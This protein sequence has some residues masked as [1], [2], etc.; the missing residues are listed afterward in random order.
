MSSDEF[1]QQ[2][3]GQYPRKKAAEGVVDLIVREASV[4]EE[5]ARQLIERYGDEDPDKLVN[6]ALHLIEDSEPKPGSEAGKV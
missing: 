5:Q 2:A 6:Y 4:T 3:H 1:I